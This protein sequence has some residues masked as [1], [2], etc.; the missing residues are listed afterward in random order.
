MAKKRKNRPGTRKA[1]PLAVAAQALQAASGMAV[2][3]DLPQEQKISNA[4][5]VLLHDEVGGDAPLSDYQKALNS[6][7]LAWNISLLDDVG[8]GIAMKTLAKELAAIKLRK[9][10]ELIEKKQALFPYDKRKVVVWDVWEE[11]RDMIRVR[12]A[13]LEAEAAS[14]AHP[15]RKLLAWIRSLVTAQ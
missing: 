10:E 9:I 1:P 12:A 7:V 4:L 14:P 13:A 8:Q 5:S 15:I 6:I 11:E 2:K 3:T